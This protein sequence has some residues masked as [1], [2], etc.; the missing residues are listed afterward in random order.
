MCEYKKVYGRLEKHF[1]TGHFCNDE[2]WG[3]NVPIEIEKNGVFIAMVGPPARGKS[4]TYNTIQSYLEKFNKSAWLYNAGDFR[5]VWEDQVKAH[6]NSNVDAFIQFCYKKKFAQQDSLES[7]REE[8]LNWLS[9]RIKAIP[10]NVFAHFK[11]LNEEFARVCIK[12]ANKKVNT[13]EIIVLDATNTDI[14]RREYIINEFKKNRSKNKTL[15][16]VENICFNEQQLKK[17]FSSKLTESGDYKTQVHEKCKNLVKQGKPL[18][19]IINNVTEEFNLLDLPCRVSN[20][21]ESNCQQTIIESMTDIV[22][23]DMG[24]LKKYV[25]LHIAK[26]GKWSTVYTIRRNKT[27]NIG[28]L[29]ILN[30]ICTTGRKKHSLFYSN[31][32]HKDGSLV[33]YLVNADVTKEIKSSYGQKNRVIVTKSDLRDLLP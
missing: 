33:D 19:N 3:Q 27:K 8:L 10:G 16:F 20:G 13:G 18:T 5:R 15:L 32:Q 23:R 26:D 14:P 12:E 6:F 21:K 25:P 9:G 31:I 30:Y 1:K 17:N 7:H 29:Q 24:Y 22:S 28:F 4:A 2:C 11:Q